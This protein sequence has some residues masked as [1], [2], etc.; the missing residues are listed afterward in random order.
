MEVIGSATQCKS[1]Q[2]LLF[3]EN[4]IEKSPDN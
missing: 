2:K 4:I 1:K 3:N